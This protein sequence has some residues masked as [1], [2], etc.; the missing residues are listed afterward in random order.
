ML[1]EAKLR[2]KTE[3]LF[4]ALLGTFGGQAMLKDHKSRVGNLAVRICLKSLRVQPTI[5]PLLQRSAAP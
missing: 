3:A 2:Q 1:L 4:D 5:F